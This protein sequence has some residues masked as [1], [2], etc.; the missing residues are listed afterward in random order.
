[1]DGSWQVAVVGG[2]LSGVMAAI[3]AAREGKRVILVERY[4]FLGGTAVMALVNP[5]MHY[6]LP[7]GPVNNAGL[8]RSLLERLKDMGALHANKHTFNEQLLAVALDDMTRE[9]GVQVLLHAQ[10]TGAETEDGPEGRRIRA[11]TVHGVS[12]QRYRISADMM[13]DATGDGDLMA[14]SGA[15]V[16][17]GRDGDNACQPM[18]LSVRIGGIDVERLQAEVKRR[19]LSGV[20]AYMDEAFAQAKAE[21]EIHIP[22][23]DVLVKPTMAA[24]VMHFN[25]TRIIG[26]S[27]LD[28]ENFTL[29]EQEGRRQAYE[30]FRFLR[31]HIVGF[32]NCTIVQMGPQIG[33]RESRRLVGQ[34]VL[35][36]DD[37]LNCCKSD[38]S[39]ARACYGVDIHN[40]D[41]EG[42]VRQRMQNDYHTIPMECLYAAEY[43]NL[44]VTGRPISSD[45]VAYSAIRIM[46]VCANLGEAAGILAA[47]ALE[48]GDVRRVDCRRVQ[49]CIARRGGIY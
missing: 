15:P 32:E 38:H 46:P 1:M 8:F 36:G 45:H 21:G 24:D 33:I 48:T 19:G 29:A 35:S 40:P 27:S 49:A 2:G 18:T 23:E 10:L 4:G 12:G 43:P 25:T 6:S 47:M 28:T 7:T 42:T 11:L 39:V 30:L 41:G 3:A 14:L 5:F 44:I 17:I 37:V 20:K 34:Y 9:A 26:R 16:A 22:R 13:V 31:K